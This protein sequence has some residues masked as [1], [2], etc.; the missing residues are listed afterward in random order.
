V[1][2]NIPSTYLLREGNFLFSGKLDI[3]ILWEGNIL[4]AQER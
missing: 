3:S 4:S 2:D 1:K